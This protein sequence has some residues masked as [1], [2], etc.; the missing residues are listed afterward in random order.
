[1]K[2]YAV[3]KVSMREH[4]RELSNLETLGIRHVFSDA[5]QL[6]LGD[7]Q[8]ELNKRLLED[9]DAVSVA[10]GDNIPGGALSG[11]EACIMGFWKGQSTMEEPHTVV[12]YKINPV[13]VD[14]PEMESLNASRVDNH[15][16]LPTGELGTLAPG[17]AVYVVDDLREINA[18]GRVYRKNQK[19]VL[20]GDVIS[21]KYETPSNFWV[22]VML[23]QAVGDIFDQQHYIYTDMFKYGE[24][25]FLDEALAEQ[26][27]SAPKA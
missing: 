1:M 9:N 23:T 21:V 20:K 27:L 26:T 24:T 11:N 2:L 4:S 22:E 15:L 25:A 19:C 17:G 12:S 7:Y 16:L 13:I 14:V 8:K 10:T 18:R 5:Y 3:E 6:M